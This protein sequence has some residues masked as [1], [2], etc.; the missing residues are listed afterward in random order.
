MKNI[1]FTLKQFN[2]NDYF[3]LYKSDARKIKLT[4]K[5]VKLLILF[6]S[7]KIWS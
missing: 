1:N 4:I 3:E 7:K 6:L 5:S 2:K